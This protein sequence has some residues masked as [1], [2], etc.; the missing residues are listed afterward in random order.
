[1]NDNSPSNF[2][3][4]LS[5]ESSLSIQS[6]KLLT[7]FKDFFKDVLDKDVSV[8]YDDKTNCLKKLNVNSQDIVDDDWELSFMGNIQTSLSAPSSPDCLS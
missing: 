3:G 5:D 7:N 8:T 6:D 1:M 2:T 4:S